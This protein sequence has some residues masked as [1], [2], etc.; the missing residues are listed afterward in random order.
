MAT[1]DIISRLINRFGNAYKDRE[2]PDYLTRDIGGHFRTNQP[3]ISGYFQVMFGVPDKIF[4]QEASTAVTWLH[5]SCESFQPHGITINTADVIGQGGVGA[6]FPTSK[7]ITRE[8]TT[9]HR[10]YQNLPLIN[11]IRLWSG[12]FDEF[13]G[14]SPFK[15]AEMIPTSYKGWAAVIQTKPTGARVG[16]P[17]QLDDIEECYI[18]QGVF[19][20]SVPIDT[21]S[22]DVT[23][24]DVAQLSVT[25]SFDGAPLTSAEDRVKERVLQMFNNMKYLDTFDKYA[26]FVK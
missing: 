5:S 1:T 22:S 16:N 20:K 19:P 12:F 11:I 21:F 4:K 13:V 2:N 6:T 17:L 9:A 25:W 18:Y 14:V 24:N 15:G 26:A 7:T 10:E 3:Y 23:A 8:F